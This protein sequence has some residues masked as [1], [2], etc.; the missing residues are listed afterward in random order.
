DLLHLSMHPLDTTRLVLQLGLV[1]AHAAAL[2]LAVLI[3]R[4]ALVGWRVSRRTWCVRVLTVAAWIA[5]LLVWKLTRASAVAQLPL[6]VALVAAVALAAAATRLGSRYRRGSQAFRLSLLTLPL[7]I[8]AFS[9]YP[10]IVQF[11]RQAKAEMV[12][13]L[14]APEVRNQRTEVQRQVQKSR[15][16]ID[17]FPGLIDLVSAKAP[18]DPDAQTD[19][20]FRVWQ[21]TAL[22]RYP[23]T[24]SVELYGPDGRLVSR[25]AFNLPEDL[26][27]TS[28]SEERSCDWDVFEEVAPFFA[29]ER[30]VL[31]AGRAFCAADPK[32]PPLGSIVVHAMPDY[33]N[34]TFISSRSPYM[35]LLRGNDAMKSEGLSGRDIEFAVYGWSRTPLYPAV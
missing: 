20:A 3:L 34:L 22:A 31:H 28:P 6:L 9:F 25:F 35:E 8:P 13:S 21:T 7:V 29:E 23:I 16:E 11:A 10:T 24:S 18:A 15:E 33:E 4:A 14:F 30:R 12:V 27:A 17:A 1:L 2:G 19:R 5:P 26:T 32:A